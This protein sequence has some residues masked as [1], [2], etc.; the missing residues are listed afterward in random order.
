MTKIRLGIAEIRAKTYCLLLLTSLLLLLGRD[1]IYMS[2]V[3][4]VPSVA[5]TPTVDKILAVVA[6]P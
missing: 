3:A 2:A 4:D 5:S 1:F 6:C